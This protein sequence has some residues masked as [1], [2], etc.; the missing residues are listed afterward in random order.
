MRTRLHVLLVLLV[1]VLAT[2]TLV[3]CAS[4]PEPATEPLPN[5]GVVGQQILDG[6]ALVAERCISCHDLQRVDDAS[7][8]DV[9]WEATVDRMIANGAKLTDDEAAAVIEYLSNR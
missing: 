3:A 7:Y 1:V 4:T 8:D 2:L 9:G 6:E 5:E